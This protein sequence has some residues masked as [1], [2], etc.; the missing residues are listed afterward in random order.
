[1]QSRLPKRMVIPV[2]ILSLV[3]YTLYLCNV[4]FSLV[5]VQAPDLPVLDPSVPESQ[6]YY[7]VLAGA[8]A[9]TILEWSAFCVALTVALLSIV[10]FRLK[11]DITTPVIGTA[12]FCAGMLDGFNA[13][14]ASRLVFQV[15]NPDHFFPFTW[16]VARTFNIVILIAGTLPFLFSRK[17]YIN[18]DRPHGIGFLVMLGI[19]FALMAYA[20]IY[21][22]AVMV[23]TPLSLLPKDAIPR[24]Y[25]GIP[26]VLAMFAA[27]VVFPRF[28]KLH[29]SLFSHSLIISM[30]PVVISECHA[31]FLSRALYDHHFIAAYLLKILA[32]LVPLFGIILDYTRAYRSEVTLQSTESKL[33]TAREIQQ[34][35]L[36]D[37]APVVDGWEMAGL[38]FP[39]EAVGGD[40][41][42]YIDMGEKTYGIVVG[43]VSGHDLGASLF[44]AQ[45]RAYLRASAAS[46]REGTEVLSQL[47]K[48]LTND[49]RDRRFVTLFFLKLDPNFNDFEY[50]GLGHG[51]YLIRRS[52]EHKELKLTH[53][54]LG[55]VDDAV[56]TN[57][58]PELNEGDMIVIMTDGIVE[59]T[60]P[61][62][63]QFGIERTLRVIR[64][65]RNQDADT[66]ISLL[67]I[68]V[69]QHC[70]SKSPTDDVTVV[71]LK[72]TVSG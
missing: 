47:N 59:A 28:Y 25:D 34:S 12:L 32:Y 41:F 18:V 65:H 64:E 51:A 45:T 1:M 60:S 17:I 71:L 37:E 61:E 9:H 40:Y 43:D 8:F 27:G 11:R 63:E 48:F 56:Q 70:Q 58:T 53:P 15:T 42:D 62:G 2:I 4:N 14:A 10:H 68:R 38:S 5:N 35:L 69:H 36:P 44:M 16:A 31:T 7:Y 33:R 55:V 54:P 21:I 39:A 13:L 3:P 57:R 46:S 26:L 49:M 29:P 66:I 67:N 19:L 24:P 23:P 20:T 6:N 22:F 30:I 72:R 50:G 52:G